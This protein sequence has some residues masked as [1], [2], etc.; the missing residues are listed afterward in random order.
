MCGG[1]PSAPA[2]VPPPETAV[3]PQKAQNDQAAVDARDRE[4][5]R[6]LAMRGMRAVMATGARG[7]TGD[8]PT[9]QKQLLGQ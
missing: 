8:A 6:Q 3:S 7:V 4:R 1:G 2:Y 9:Q 5:K